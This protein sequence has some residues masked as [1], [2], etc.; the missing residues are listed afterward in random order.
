MERSSQSMDTGRYEV[1]IEGSKSRGVRFMHCHIIM[2]G[3]PS[4]C[5]PL[6]INLI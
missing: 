3:K 4:S 5:S 1:P 6:R 2:R